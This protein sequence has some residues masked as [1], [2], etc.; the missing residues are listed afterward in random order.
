VRA[1]VNGDVQ[2]GGFKISG[3]TVNVAGGD[4]AGVGYDEKLR[5][6]K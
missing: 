5:D 6:A 3:G 2:A 4:D 1:F